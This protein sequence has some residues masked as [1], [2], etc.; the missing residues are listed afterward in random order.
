MFDN[1]GREWITLLRISKYGL[2]S[3]HQWDKG[4]APSKEIV[5]WLYVSGTPT[6]LEP[7]QKSRQIALLVLAPVMHSI[8]NT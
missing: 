8:F 3:I 1:L 4:E 6:T 5:I 2:L 7:E